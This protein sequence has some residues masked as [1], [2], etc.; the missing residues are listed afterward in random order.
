MCFGSL[1]RGSLASWDTAPLVAAGGS[2]RV[3]AA[4]GELVLQAEHLL[5]FETHPFEYPSNDTP[6]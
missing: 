1:E 2:E 6:E 5:F 4:S 3:M